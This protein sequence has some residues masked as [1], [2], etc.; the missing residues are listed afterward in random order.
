MIPKRLG[1]RVR[2]EWTFP[3]GAPCVRV[4]S[5]QDAQ[6]ADHAETHQQQRQQHMQQEHA[7]AAVGGQGSIAHAG[8]SGIHKN[9]HCIQIWLEG[10]V[11]YDGRLESV[12]C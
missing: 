6:V 11:V 8:P 12:R 1:Q 3:V 4:F 5:E 7:A 10:E 2:L 9:P